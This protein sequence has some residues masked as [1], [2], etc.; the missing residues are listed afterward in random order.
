MSN[1]QIQRCIRDILGINQ[2]EK[3]DWSQSHFKKLLSATST[4][5]TASLNKVMLKQDEETA[6][7]HLCAYIASERLADKHMPELSYY[8]DRVPLEPR[9]ARKLMELIK[10]NVFQLS[11]VKNIQWTPSPKK[12]N[13]TSPLK[14]GDRFTA[15]DP[16]ILRKQLFDTPTKGNSPVGDPVKNAQ[17]VNPPSAT[18]SP[19]KARRK[20]AFEEEDEMENPVPA[21]NQSLDTLAQLSLV[22]NE[23]LNNEEEEEELKKK[24]RSNKRSQQQQEQEQ[25]QPAPK[26]RKET[27]RSRSEMCL[28]QKR[29]YKVTPAEIINLCNQFEIPKD[30]AYSILDQFM[31]YA[32]YLVCPWKL[33]CGLVLNATFVVFTERRRKDPRVDH[34]ILE[35]MCGI[36]KAPQLED[37]T[38]CINLVKELIEGEKWYRDLQIKH[39]YYNGACFDEA[40]S[41]KLGSMLQPNNILVSNEQFTSWKR[42]IEQDLSLKDM[43]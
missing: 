34:L 31:S 6:R 9:K 40:I 14:N 38:E 22:A 36:T 41:T 29:Y 28:L 18:A 1:H 12:R 30:V 27:G 4:L 19:S 10:Q 7:L 11:P 23:R 8:M 42:K 21:S 16:Q 39:N 26:R 5:H 3:L 37:I 35:K 17:V 33:A 15:Q 2:E 25:E 20:L 43:H 13:G 32:S 24:P